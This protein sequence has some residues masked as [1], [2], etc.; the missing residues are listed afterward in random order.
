MGLDQTRIDWDSAAAPALG[1]A[2][3]ATRPLGAPGPQEAS[4]WPKPSAL[5]ALLVGAVGGSALDME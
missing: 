1:Q 2:A 5:R 4:S 3:A